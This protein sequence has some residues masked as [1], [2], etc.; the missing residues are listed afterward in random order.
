MILIITGVILA[1]VGFRVMLDQDE[2][3]VVGYV[4]ILV[5]ILLVPLDSM[6]NL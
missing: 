2:S 3:M 4:A 6:L 5:G 1:I